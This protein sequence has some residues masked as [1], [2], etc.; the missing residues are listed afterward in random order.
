VIASRLASPIGGVELWVAELDEGPP[1]DQ[2]VLSAPE[3]ARAERLASERRRRRYVASHVVLRTLLGESLGVEPRDVAIEHG[4]HGKPYVP[5]AAVTFSL[6]HSSSLVVVAVAG[7]AEVGVDV[8]R[9]REVDVDRLARAACSDTER[10]RL[11]GAAQADHAARFLT[12]WTAKEA[13]LK[14]LGA[15][16]TVSPAN[17]DVGAILDGGTTIC[18]GTEVATLAPAPG[19]VG[20]VATPRR[21]RRS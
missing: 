18:L 1:P 7:E 14:A 20:A 2:A 10:E 15:G 9:L 19:Y 12:L 11:A 4:D 8:E 3:R 16:L 21:P 6:A 5:G 17:A 13:C